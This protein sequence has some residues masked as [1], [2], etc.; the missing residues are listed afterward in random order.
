[1]LQGVGRGA[2][3]HQGVGWQRRALG[4]VKALHAEYGASVGRERVGEKLQKR[5]GVLWRWALKHAEAK[6]HITT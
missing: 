4:P 5:D 1:M 2:L 6:R 3:R